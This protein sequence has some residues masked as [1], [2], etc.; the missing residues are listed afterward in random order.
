MCYIVLIMNNISSF[1]QE[2]DILE[3][4]SKS[5]DKVR[6]RYLSK[7]L[8]ISLG[9]TNV[10]L[11][12]LVKKGL[13]KIQKIN[14]RRIKYLVS[15]RG[16]EEIAKRSFRYFKYTVKNVINYK[17]S[18]AKLVLDIKKDGFPGISLLG[19]SDIDFLIEYAC[20]K[21][22]LKF[23]REEIEC[24]FI[25]YSENYK[26]DENNDHRNNSANLREIVVNI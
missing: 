7:C 1:E 24:F 3:N 22:G 9:L 20:L 14:N 17:E 15:S 21:C 13:L 11:K 5:K 8:G 16:L 19:N 12:R 6:Q 25:I 23:A 10:I 2:I 18:I 26:S 4:I